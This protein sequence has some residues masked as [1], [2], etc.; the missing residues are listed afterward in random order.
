M[1]KVIYLAYDDTRF[2]DLNEGF[3]YDSAALRSVANDLWFIRLNLE[4]D[5]FNRIPLN[6]LAN[7]IESFNHAADI[8]KIMELFILCPIVYCATDKAAKVLTGV[9]KNPRRTVMVDGLSKGINYWFD[10]ID[11]YC[12]EEYFIDSLEGE[13]LSAFDDF[14]AVINTFIENNGLSA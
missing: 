3:A 4:A 14:R 8:V 9:L 13:A 10:G 1:N 6:K 7:S 12:H 5:S 2:E 11:K